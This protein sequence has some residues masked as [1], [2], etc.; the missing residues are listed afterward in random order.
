VGSK[1]KIDQG[2]QPRCCLND[3]ITPTAAISTVWPTLGNIFFPS[4]A[5]ATVTAVASFDKKFR[6]IN[7]RHGKS[8]I[9][10]PLAYSEPTSKKRSKK[11]SA[12]TRSDDR[13]DYLKLPV[14]TVSNQSNQA[15]G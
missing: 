6:F 12:I 10:G 3:N 15:G 13:V 5:D 1:F 7:K 14:R 11:N 4:K 8:K 9:P 2:L